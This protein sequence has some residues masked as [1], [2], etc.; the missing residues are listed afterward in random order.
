MSKIPNNLV[1]FEMANNHM[2]SVS[3]GIEIISKF[4]KFITEFPNFSFAFKL[5]YRDLDT[6]I[7]PDYVGRMDI[8]HVRR[9]EETRL[10]S[11]EQKKLIATMEGANFLKICTPFDESSVNKVV[12]D[13]FDILKIASCSFG[14]WPLLEKAASSG[15]PI[16]AST[17]GA[18]AELIDNVI[19][20][21]ENRETDFILQ[22]CVGEYPTPSENVSLNQ[23]DYLRNR[24]PNIRFGF[25]THESPS[26]TNLVRMAIAKGVTSLEKH[27]G[28]PTTDWPLNAYSSNIQET[29][30]WLDAAHQALLVCGAC[31]GRYSPSAREMDSLRGLQRGVFAKTNIKKGHKLDPNNVYFA[32]PPSEGQLTAADFSKYNEIVATSDININA[33]V[34][35]KVVKILNHRQTLLSYAEEVIDL[36]KKSGAVVPKKFELEISHHFGLERFK[37]FGLSMITTINR[38]YCKKVLICLPGQCHPEQ[39]HLKKEE[40]FNVLYGSIKLTLENENIDL[41]VGDVATIKPNQKHHF[42]SQDGAVLEEISTTHNVDDSYY[43]DPRVET[44]KAR[45]SFVKWVM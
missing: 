13:G 20:F 42:I 41:S 43:T 18:S 24:H 26:D 27:V 25:S 19:S 45:K 21:F 30:D 44:N 12:Q 11:V 37:E 29:R 7:R 9:F 3:H 34:S 17:A 23:L 35:K 39:Y 32:F 31:T 33:E 4:S 15:L 2:G 1:I 5:Q 10:S 16:I 14:D 36:L 8:K 38:D 6:F 40:T 28:I 22:H